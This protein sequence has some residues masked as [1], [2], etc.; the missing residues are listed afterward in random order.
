MLDVHANPILD[1]NVIEHQSYLDACIKQ[2][3]N[4]LFVRIIKKFGDEENVINQLSQKFNIA[5]QYNNTRIIDYML[6]NKFN[7]SRYWI[8]IFYE[9]A[10][11]HKNNALGL[12]IINKLGHSRDMLINAIKYRILD[13]VKY[14][15]KIFI[16]DLSKVDIIKVHQI[17][18]TFTDELAKNG[19]KITNKC[20]SD[21]IINHDSKNLLAL[22]QYVKNLNSIS[23]TEFSILSLAIN[24]IKT[25]DEKVDTSIIDV[26]LGYG[27]NPKCKNDKGR[28]IME[29]ALEIWNNDKMFKDIIS[30]IA[31]CIKY[32]TW[33]N[34]PSLIGYAIKHDMLCI[35]G[36]KFVEDINGL[37]EKQR[38]PISLAVV[39]RKPRI[40]QQIL[41]CGTD[42]NCLD[43]GNN[44][45]LWNAIATDR[46]CL[47][48][49]L[50][51]AKF[52][53]W[54]LPCNRGI[55]N[56]CHHEEAKMIKESPNIP[57]DKVSSYALESTWE[58]IDT[59]I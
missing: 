48:I 38:P 46:D 20:I 4:N 5:V 34:K 23:F 8:D 59:D 43:K 13:H 41:E 58:I 32:S 51:Y 57:L 55:L 37:I 40:F 7:P 56:Y 29:Y 28:N 22:L 15:N 42:I 25:Q 50:S 1:N 14:I 26:L 24:N 21:C 53:N 17:P 35:D 27:I 2:K 30:A 45:C 31:K 39:E 11:S 18:H 49:I 47:K 9:N 6:N 12:N 54:D 3:E 19:V 10:L 52:I 36:L 33:L 44:S 16:Y